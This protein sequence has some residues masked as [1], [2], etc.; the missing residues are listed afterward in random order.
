MKNVDWIALTE[1]RDK[2]RAFVNTVMS[3]PVP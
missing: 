1:E 3:L 2:R